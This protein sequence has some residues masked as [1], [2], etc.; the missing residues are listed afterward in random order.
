MRHLLQPRVLNQAALAAAVSALAAYPAFDLLMRVPGGVPLLEFTIFICTTVL[1]GF[2]FAWHTPYTSRPVFA[3][4]ESRLFLAVTALGLVVAVVYAAWLDPIVRP[5]LPKE[6]PANYPEWFA[7][8]LFNL[9]LQQL[10]LVFAPYDW[11][12]R[13]TKRH[14]VAIVFT[15][16]FAAAVPIMKL[17]LMNVQLSPA[18]LALMLIMWALGG[19]LAVTFYLRGGIFLVCWWALLLQVRLLLYLNTTP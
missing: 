1:W 2:V 6:Y 5:K 15:M 11:C 12:L 18:L 4:P 14:R 19:Y 9:A 16:L 3:K 10:F 8:T 7:A 17:H 13:L